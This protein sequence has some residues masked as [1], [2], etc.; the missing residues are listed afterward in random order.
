MAHDLGTEQTLR[1]PVV[2]D[3]R[4][5]LRPLQEKQRA[6]CFLTCIFH[7]TEHLLSLLTKAAPVPPSIFLAQ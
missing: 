3:G 2:T 6:P 7:S 1:E 4:C 5:Q